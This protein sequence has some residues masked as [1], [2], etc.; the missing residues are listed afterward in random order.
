MADKRAWAKIDLGYLTNPKMA[1][2]LDE[3]STATLMHLASILHC[4]QHLT[5]GHASP[6]AMQ[7]MVGGSNQDAELLIESG[8]WHKPGHTCEDCPQ[9][10]LGR[11]Y[12]HNYLEHNRSAHD[13]HKVSQA[14]SEAAKA[15]WNPKDEQSAS[16]L[17]SKVGAES[18]AE[19]EKE[20]KEK[21]EGQI[22]HLPHT[23]PPDFSITDEMRA[24][25]SHVAPAVN[26]DSETFDFIDY[27]TNGKGAGEKKKDWART[28]Q[29]NMKRKQQW[30]ERDGWKPK[31][32]PEKD[33]TNPMNW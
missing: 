27:W 9:P 18:N 33:L 32:P 23:L 8:L 31:P 25:A 12:V 24:W 7:R 1:D 11:I 15:R 26:I 22:T 17:D 5:D 29:N 30:A 13:A 10:D 6:K 21:K 14:R 3:S 19:R 16:K 2:V 4:A 20:K 28:W